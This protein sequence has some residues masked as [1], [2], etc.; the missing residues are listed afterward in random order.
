[1]HDLTPQAFNV[2]FMHGSYKIGQVATVRL[3]WDKI[4]CTDSRHFHLE[5]SGGLPQV[6]E[7]IDHGSNFIKK[8]FHF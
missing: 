4:L 5:F 8:R 6:V 7:L 2:V 3:G 1:V